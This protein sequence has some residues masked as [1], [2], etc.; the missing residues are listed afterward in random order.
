MV[1]AGPLGW[2]I[3]GGSIMSSIVIVAGDEDMR[4]RCC[5]EQVLR[6]DGNDDDDETNSAPI[7]PNNR[8]ETCRKHGMLLGELASH[9]EVLKTKEETNESEKLILKNRYGE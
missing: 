1:A 5:W 3:L 6:I 8:I 4:E 9:C 7:I 2:V